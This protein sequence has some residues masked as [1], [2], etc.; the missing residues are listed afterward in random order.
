[1]VSN[2]IK[3]FQRTETLA[4]IAAAFGCNFTV[5]WCVHAINCHI[6]SAHFDESVGIVCEH[7][8]V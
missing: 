3:T 7:V 2:I 4:E 8:G 6:K 1:M 5:H